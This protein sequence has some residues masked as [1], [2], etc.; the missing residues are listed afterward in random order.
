MPTEALLGG[1]T[2]VGVAGALVSAAY[3]GAVSHS[4]T[5]FGRAVSNG[6]ANRPAIALTFDDGPSPGSLAIA[7]F[8]EAHDIKATFFQCGENVL[9]HPEIARELQNA[10]HEIGNHTLTHRRL[11]PRI[12]WQ[13]NLLSPQTIL[14]EFSQ[15]QEIIVETTGAVPRVMRPPYGLRWRGVGA[16][17]RELGLTTVLWSVIGHDWEWPAA[18]VA[19]HVVSNAGP[20]GIICL[21]DGRD[22]RSQPDIAETLKAVRE[23]VPRLQDLGYRFETVSA[24]IRP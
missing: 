19:H 16:A 10:G 13:L 14:H 3:Y 8:L 6:P 21:H 2:A 17:Q 4:A 22:T 12:G 24:I 23:I 20:G 5:L 11:C 15:A 18:Q 7:Q 9:R 1:V